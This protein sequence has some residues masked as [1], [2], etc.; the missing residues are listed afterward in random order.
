MEK[1]RGKLI[2]KNVQVTKRVADWFEK[3]AYESGI[4]QSSLMLMAL[5]SYIDQQ[6]SMNMADSLE[7]ISKKLKDLDLEE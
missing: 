1:E 6:K 7:E 2:R 3:E 4:S 5:S